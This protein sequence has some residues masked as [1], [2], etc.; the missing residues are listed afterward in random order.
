M[1]S[2]AD[3]LPHAFWRAALVFCWL[4]YAFRRLKIVEANAREVLSPR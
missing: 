4:Q 2:D 1:S 3:L